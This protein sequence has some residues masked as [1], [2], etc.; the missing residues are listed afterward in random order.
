MHK[1]TAFAIGLAASLQAE[2]TILSFSAPPLYPDFLAGASFT[3]TQA[4][5]NASHFIQN[6]Q[7]IWPL[8]IDGNVPTL[9]VAVDVPQFPGQSLSVAGVWFRGPGVDAALPSTFTMVG[10]L[11]GIRRFE[12]SFDQL[13]A[14]NYTLELRSGS[15]ASGNYYI[16]I[17]EVPEPSAALLGA[18]GV[19]VLGWRWR[20]AHRP[21]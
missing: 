1:L 3:P 6:W 8:T 14:G 11:G 19:L 16:Q 9:Q 5:G 10:S 15:P 7:D 13:A 17:S 2:A 21:A 18:I 12:M 20:A 4:S